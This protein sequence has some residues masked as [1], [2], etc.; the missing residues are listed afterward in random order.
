[1]LLIFVYSY[2]YAPISNFSLLIITIFFFEFNFY[3]HSKIIELKIHFIKK[4]K[5]ALKIDRND[6]KRY[7]KMKVE[8][9]E[10]KKTETSTKDAVKE[11]VKEPKEVKDADTLTFEG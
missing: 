10:T 4:K 8:K 5:K 3:L 1:M 9:E 2:I 7:K 6:K 11:T